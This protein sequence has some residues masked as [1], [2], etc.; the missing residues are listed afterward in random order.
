MQLILSSN[1]DL[2]PRSRDVYAIF[3]AVLLTTDRHLGT[4]ALAIDGT[5]GSGISMSVLE[6]DQKTP[7]AVI[8]GGPLGP[9]GR[10]VLRV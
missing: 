2:G 3:V 4:L 10:D 5:Q 8:E 1:P 7:K 9:G 6:K